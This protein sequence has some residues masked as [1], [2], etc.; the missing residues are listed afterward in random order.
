LRAEH[1]S[2]VESSAIINLNDFD[3]AD[4]QELAVAALLEDAPESADQQLG[5]LLLRSDG[6]DGDPAG[7]VRI[8]PAEL[9]VTPAPSP[10]DPLELIL[11]EP[12]VAVAAGRRQFAPLWGLAASL[13]LLISTALM[14]L[15]AATPQELNRLWPAPFWANV[16]ASWRQAPTVAQAR[17]QPLAAT[18]DKLRPASFTAAKAVSA[19]VVAEEQQPLPMPATAPAADESPLPGQPVSATTGGGS[20]TPAELPFSELAADG[21]PKIREISFSLRQ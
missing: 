11:Q 4:L 10:P 1:L 9:P 8:E 21:S 3:E 2:A 15:L 12:P 16:A 20:L 17:E 14:T 7:H 13:L 18:P 5:E 6:M 19:E